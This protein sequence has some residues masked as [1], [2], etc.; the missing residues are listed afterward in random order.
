MHTIS[1]TFKITTC[2]I[3]LYN[4]GREDRGR[5]GDGERE[6]EKVKEGGRK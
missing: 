3:Y 6:R 1:I 4:R 5:E 2:I